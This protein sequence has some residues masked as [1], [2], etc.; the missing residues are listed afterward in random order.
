MSSKIQSS[1]EAQYHQLL[2]P[3]RLGALTLPNRVVMSPLTRARATRDHR[4]TA[5]MA[6]Y[7]AQRAT[8][9]LIIAEASMVARD[10]S[11]FIS[12]PGIYAQEHVTDWRQIT[13]A[14]HAAGG[15]IIVQLWH[16]GRA[17]HSLLDHGVQPVSSTDRAVLGV[18]IHTPDGKK[19][20]ETP[21]RLA[22]DELP[23][24]VD[25]FRQGTRRAMDAGFDGVQVH[26]A[27]GYLL[28]QFL[29]DG[30]ND[31]QGL[32]GGSIEKRARLL[33]EVVDAAVQEA[34]AGRVGVR[35]SPL[36]GFGD[37]Q[38]SDTNAWVGHV[39]RE[40]GQRAIAFMELRHT[41]QSKPEEVA[42]AQMVKREFGG[43]LLRNGG[44]DPASAE[45]ALLDGNADAI[46]FGKH[47]I[48]NPDLVQRIRQG[49]PLADS[50]PATYYKGGVG[51][52][53]DYPMLA[54]ATEGK[55][56]CP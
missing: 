30:V 21:R 24:I 55:A 12:E 42:L 3:V 40:L 48:G 4:P 39:S 44:F 49:A 6:N 31:R 47:F 34:G 16:P 10:A 8:A 2:S 27:H 37:L 11:A 35:L 33:L 36:H 17:S 23:G 19:P 1:G 5:L 25:L 54:E 45:T 51:G 43:A 53:S 14:V 22:D 29:R 15:R 46:V 18:E 20:Y 7:Y 41:H 50:D 28:D 32:Y 38:D 52:Y 56:L 13:D 9:G 26:G